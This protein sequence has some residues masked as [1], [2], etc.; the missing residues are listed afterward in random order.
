VKDNSHY[1][2]CEYILDGEKTMSGAH[3][4][5]IMRGPYAGGIG[6]SGWSA[7]FAAPHLAE[8]AK[9]VPK[10]ESPS[11]KRN[12]KSY[13]LTW[14]EGKVSFKAVFI[15]EED[16][17]GGPVY[18]GEELVFLSTD[19]SSKPIEAAPKKVK[20]APKGKSDKK[21]KGKEKSKV[22]EKKETVN[23]SWN[24]VENPESL[25]ETRLLP[26]FYHLCLQSPPN[27]IVF[28]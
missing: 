7:E 14:D 9:K 5:E 15:L 2:Y 25:Q 6:Y 20:A 24:P 1:V 28:L 8:F 22:E 21:G 18:R 13:T 4:R 26:L 3:F 10:A 17:F 23:I 27:G 16:A 19:I 12:K 11:L